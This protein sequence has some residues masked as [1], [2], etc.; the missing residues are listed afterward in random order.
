MLSVGGV[1]IVSVASHLVGKQIKQM[2]GS[3]LTGNIEQA[4]AINTK[5]LPL[6]K[7][8][9]CTTNPI[10]VKAALNLRGWNVGGVRLPLVAL[11]QPMQADL[12][13][14]LQELL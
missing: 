5:Y 9:F 3:F 4:E 6:F 2:I 7:A 8:L 10:A 13:K 11:S 14:V 12:E 1:G